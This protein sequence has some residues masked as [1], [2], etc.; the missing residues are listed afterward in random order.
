M[1]PSIFTY[2]YADIIALPLNQPTSQSPVW[3]AF[4][5]ASGCLYRIF[6]CDGECA[7]QKRQRCLISG[8]FGGEEEQGYSCN[9]RNDSAEIAQVNVRHNETKSTHPGG[10]ED[11]IDCF[12][13]GDYLELL[14]LVN[15]RSSSSSSDNSS[16]VSLASDEVFDYLAL[17]DDLDPE[18][19]KENKSKSTSSNLSVSLC[20]ASKK[21]LVPP[22]MSGSMA[23]GEANWSPGDTLNAEHHPPPNIRLQ[24]KVENEN[25]GQTN[26]AENNALPNSQE[27]STS[28]RPMPPDK[29]KKI[30]VGKMK[31][32]KYFCFMSF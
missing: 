2:M 21:V 26:M 17:L 28:R 13:T 4:L 23:S 32:L 30:A 9:S 24:G 12:S 1:V 15:P 22:A 31:M 3:F 14:D 11:D 8:S 29:G 7:K 25:D 16:W 10:N 5:Q 20:S 19:I 6:P 27:A 18:S